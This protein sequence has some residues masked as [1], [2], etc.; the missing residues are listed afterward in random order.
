MLSIQDTL[1]ARTKM[2][3]QHGSPI[4]IR[5]ISTRP[6]IFSIGKPDSWRT[7]R[8]SIQV[9]SDARR[10]TTYEVRRL[11]SRA[12]WEFA[13]RYNVS[14]QGS[15]DDLRRRVV[16][17]FNELELEAN[18]TADSQMSGGYDVFTNEPVFVD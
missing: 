16:H 15:R 13:R 11:S 2:T 5:I 17:L 8:F 18:T 9:V 7:K 12:G 14:D 1:D 6:A 10:D 3:N 4:F